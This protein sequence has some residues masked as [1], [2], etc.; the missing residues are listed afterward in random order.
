MLDLTYPSGPAPLLK[1]AKSVRAAEMLPIVD[2]SGCVVA[3]APREFCHSG[4]KPLHPVVHLHIIDR[5]G[6]I[7]LQKRAAHKKIAPL[8]WDTAVGGHITYGETVAEAL[9]RESGEE[10][11]FY[12]YNPYQYGTYV[13][14]S[15]VE[16][17]LIYVFAAVGN[18]TLK[19]DN[20]EVVEGRWWSMEE[21]EQNIGRNI[22]TSNFESEF[23]RIKNY[24]LALL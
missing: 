16:R 18:F 13:Y 14:E 5:E 21:I 11:G 23:A 24:L 8:R 17:E 9:F 6:R 22:L 2:E 7:Y 10:I 4:S 20:D 12:D 3:Q 15:K 19:P 1:G